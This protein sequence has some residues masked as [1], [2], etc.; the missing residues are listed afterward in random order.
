M[1]VCTVSDCAPGFIR[2]KF[3]GH[4]ICLGCY[5]ICKAGG[6]A[7]GSIRYEYRGHICLGC[8]VVMSADESALA[9]IWYRESIIW[10]IPCIPSNSWCGECTASLVY[11]CNFII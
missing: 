1:T 4:M 5:V 6:C 11:A 10:Y 9:Y 3:R 7:P 2:Y 8:Y